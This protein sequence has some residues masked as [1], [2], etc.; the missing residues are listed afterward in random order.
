MDRFSREQR[1]R[2]MSRIRAKNT[3]PELLLRKYLF[4]RGLRYR[5]H[6]RTLPGAPDLVFPGRKVAV[7]VD[8]CF[9]HGHPGCKKAT[10]PKTNTD[11]WRAKIEGNQARDRAVNA[12]LLSRGWHV[13]RVWECELSSER[14][15]TV[16]QAIE[17]VPRKSR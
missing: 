6:V 14:L 3:K 13:I 2:T 15:E 11:Y 7:F 16:T 8:G 5:L 12:T 4:K 17:S 10:T 1:S 9:W